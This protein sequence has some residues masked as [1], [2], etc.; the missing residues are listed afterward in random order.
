MFISLLPVISYFGIMVGSAFEVALLLGA[1]LLLV[2]VYSNQVLMSRPP[3]FSSTEFPESDELPLPGELIIMGRRLP[4]IPF[5]AAL[6]VVIAAP[7]LLFLTTQTGI[8]VLDPNSPITA[9]LKLV[10]TLPIIWAFAAAGGVYAYGTAAPFKRIRDESREYEDDVLDGLYH[11]ANRLSENRPPEDSLMYV[12]ETLPNTRI[13][14]L[15]KQT[16]QLVKRR[17]VTMEQAFFSE[18]FGTLRGVHSKTVKSIMFLFVNSARK[19]VKASSEILFTIVDHFHEVRK[20]EKELNDMMQKSISM[21][22]TTVMVFAPLVCGIVVVMHDRI[23]S[24]MMHAQQQMLS[25]GYDVGMV[26]A[27]MAGKTNVIDSSVLQLLVGVFIVILSVILVRY[28][29]LIERGPDDV[30]FKLQL[31]RLLPLSAAVFTVTL[32]LTN[33]MIGG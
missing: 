12:N 28:I 16:A 19:G 26:T 32:V 27:L 5:A 2:Y 1:V 13:G 30:E 31:S 23:Q 7:G 24:A 3:S 11:L 14:E 29:V 20:T 4:A 6:F 8:I 18:K 21:L 33:I 10:N 17:N 22:R 25:M 15:F 9:A